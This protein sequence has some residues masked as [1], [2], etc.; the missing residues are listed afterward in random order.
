MVKR[1]KKET[2]F[3]SKLSNKNKNNIHIYWAK[4]NKI[5]RSTISDIILTS[6]KPEFYFTAIF[7]SQLIFPELYLKRNSLAPWPATYSATFMSW[8]HVWR[9]CFNLKAFFW[10]SLYLKSGRPHPWEPSRPWASHCGERIEVGT[11]WL[12]RAPLPATS[13]KSIL[14]YA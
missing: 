8:K 3:K 13:G 1:N 14:W 9:R 2:V 4:L 11:Q 10:G 12:A 7:F 5:N 6:V